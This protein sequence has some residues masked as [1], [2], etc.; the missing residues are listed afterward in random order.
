[1]NKA[2]AVTFL[3]KHQPLPDDNQIPKAVI[4]KYDEVRIYFLK[5]PDKVCMPLLLNSFGEGD[6]YGIYPLV[7]NVLRNFNPAEVTP[8]LKE[9]LSSKYQSVRYWCT[10]IAASFPSSILIDPLAKMLAEQDFDMKYVAITALEQIADTRV[11]SVLQEAYKQES[12]PELKP[13]IEEIITE[14]R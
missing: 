11:A 6:G 12:D 5:N 1:M 2:Q 3:K 8:Y 7:E 4:E 10:Q 9:G 13:L 14:K